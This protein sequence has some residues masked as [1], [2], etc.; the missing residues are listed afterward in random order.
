MLFSMNKN[1]KWTFSFLV[2]FFICGNMNIFTQEILAN[3]SFGGSYLDSANIVNDHGKIDVYHNRDS[4][5]Q[6]VTN[7]TII[8]ANVLFIGNSGFTINTGI[9]II[10]NMRNYGTNID[11]VAGIGYVYYNRIYIGGIL[12]VI[13]KPYLEY[14]HGIG[15]VF[16]VPTLV[17][18]LDFGLI[19]L[20]GQISYMYGV[21][22][23]ISGFKFTLS[24][25]VNVSKK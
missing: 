8:G 13:P 2:L 23:S 14:D 9:D 19:L 15:E 22:S 24:V 5:N 20:G 3:F 7:G 10:F 16:I 25:G 21:M 6:T 17:G 1:I 18:G 4:Y 11:P 12:N